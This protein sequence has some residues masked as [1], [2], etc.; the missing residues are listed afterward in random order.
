V[1]PKSVQK[2]HPPIW[3]ACSRRETIHEAARNGIGAL[4]FAFI[5]P[6]EAVKW[7]KEYYD[8]IKSEACVPIG[9]T[10][11]AEIAMVCGFSCHADADEARRRGL[12]GFRF[13]GYALGHHYIF[14]EHVP[15][16]TSIWANYEKARDLLPMSAG[17]GGIGTPEQI[18]ENMRLFEEAGVDQVVFLQQGGMNRHEHIC[19]SLELFANAVMP[20]FKARQPERD[21]RKRAELAAHIEAALARRKRR[22]PIADA[23]IPKLVALGRQV[24]QQESADGKTANF[25][26]GSEMLV[27]LEDPAKQ[28][29]AGG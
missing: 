5:D 28:A 3:I 9:H 1:V 12:D 7:V 10:V 25:G 24:A 20:A 23:E 13:F 15:G 11:N 19:A 14:G 8:I 27:P 21:A 29:R 26:R 16:R 6:A 18:A 22:P 17:A 4:T 2:P